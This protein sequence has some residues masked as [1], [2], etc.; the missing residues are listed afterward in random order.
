MV[1]LGEERE[2]FA[3]ADRKAGAAMGG[4]LFGCRQRQC[5]FPQ[6]L[7]QPIWIA[8]AGHIGSQRTGI[9]LVFGNQDAGGEGVK[10]ITREDRD[11]GLG[12]H[13]SVIQLRRHDVHTAPGNFV[14]RFQR[15]FMRALKRHF[16]INKAYFDS[17]W[18]QMQAQ[19]L[20]A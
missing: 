6:L 9:G 15:T 8:L 17:L 7:H 1:V 14:A 12:Q 13:W 16:E 20:S 19:R 18:Q 11:F 3:A 5:A 2:E 10:G 4:P